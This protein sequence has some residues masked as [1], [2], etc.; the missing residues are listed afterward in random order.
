MLTIEGSPEEG[1]Q[2]R[3]DGVDLGDSGVHIVVCNTAGKQSLRR[4]F[5][6]R[7]GEGMEIP[8]AE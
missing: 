8:C 6:E 5:G 1:E 4:Q 3:Q 2:N 7:L